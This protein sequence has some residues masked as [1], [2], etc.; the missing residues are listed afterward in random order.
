MKDNLFK[1]ILANEFNDTQE[2][3][4]W[5]VKNDYIDFSDTGSTGFSYYRV[6][7]EFGWVGHSNRYNK[8]LYIRSSYLYEG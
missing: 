7:K 8:V 1:C 2:N 6:H 4:K 5:L 3:V